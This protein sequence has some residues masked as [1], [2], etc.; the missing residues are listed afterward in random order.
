MKKKSIIRVLFAVISI[1]LIYDNFWVSSYTNYTTKSYDL[2][3]NSDITNGA[4]S[5]LRDKSYEF[6]LKDGSKITYGK[7]TQKVKLIQ[8]DKMIF[9]LTSYIPFSKTTT[10][11]IRFDC[12]ID[13]TGKYIGKIEIERN[14]E[15][16]GLFNRNRMKSHILRDYINR[17]VQILNSKA[18]FY[19]ETEPITVL[20]TSG[21]S[22]SSPDHKSTTQAKIMVGL[23]DIESDF[24]RNIP[25]RQND[26][27]YE[28]T[29][30]FKSGDS[31][32]GDLYYEI[33]KVDKPQRLLSYKGYNIGNKLLYT[34][35]FELEEVDEHESKSYYYQV[36]KLE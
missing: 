32:L 36:N 4:L 2:G 26:L 6:I 30:Y 12:Y 7:G 11:L 25:V 15:M 22:V 8:K 9:G 27:V 17:T 18:I 34:K 35:R 31:R 33:Y 29:I 3:T 28:D 5:Q 24:V 16:S 23:L 14:Y 13:Q 1:I 19:N 10:P 21:M 20:T